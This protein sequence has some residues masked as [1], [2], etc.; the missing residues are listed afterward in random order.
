MKKNILRLLKSLKMGFIWPGTTCFVPPS[1]FRWRGRTFPLRLPREKS[2]GWVFRD[3]VLDDEYGLQCLPVSPRTILDVGANV[4]MFSLWA[5]ANFPGAI[6]HSY[7]PNSDLQEFLRGNLG[8]VG[9]ILHAEGVSGRDGFGSF[10]QQ[11]ES[12]LGQCNESE[13]GDI[14][15]VSLRSAIERMGGGDVDLLKLD[16]E[17]AE[18]SIL[19]QAEAFNAVRYVRMEYHLIDSSHSTERLIEAFVNMGF[20]CSHLNPNQG[21]G[22]AWFDRK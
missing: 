6:I 14:P 19:K 12:M 17:G 21:F 4:G 2:L 3:V 16:C 11:G 15:V 18:W 5:R 13:S 1:R 10:A 20:R 22:L 7:E 9:A 8:Q